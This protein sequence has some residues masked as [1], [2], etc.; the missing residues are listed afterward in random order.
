VLHLEHSL[1][2]GGSQITLLCTW[3]YVSQLNVPAKIY[4][5][6]LGM[7][8]GSTVHLLIFVCIFMFCFISMRVAYFK[9]IFGMQ[10]SYNLKITCSMCL[11]VRGLSL[12]VKLK[13]PYIS[14]KE[15]TRDV[16]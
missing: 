11:M 12:L 1:G 9:L 7:G 13:T 14:P 6:Q 2:G 3:C 8:R 15:Q 5:N 16:R 4:T 10:I